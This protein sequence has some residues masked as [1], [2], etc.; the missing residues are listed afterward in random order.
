MISALLR[1]LSR[2][3][4]KMLKVVLVDDEPSVLEGLR[5]FVDWNDLGFEVA[6]EASDSESAYA[7]ILDKRPNLVVCDIRMPSVSGFELM[8]KVQATMEDA[9]RFIMISGYC[10]F[11][12]AQRAL[13]MG[14]LGYITKP[15]DAGDIKDELENAAALLSRSSVLDEE[16]RVGAF[17]DILDGNRDQESEAS[18]RAA[19]GSGPIF[20]VAI[21]EALGE[22]E[23]GALSILQEIGGEG[24]FAFGFGIGEFALVSSVALPDSG[25]YRRAESSMA[26]NRKFCLLA[27]NE[28]EA[29]SENA[30]EAISE[31]LAQIDKLQLWRLAHP[32]E[33]FVSME[34][35]AKTDPP[36]SKVFELPY[37]R[38][39]DALKDQDIKEAGAAVEELFDMLNQSGVD[40]SVYYICL[41]RLADVIARKARQA[42][43]D[44]GEALGEF[45]REASGA[46]RLSLGK[47]LQCRKKAL[48]MCQLAIERKNDDAERVAEEIVEYIKANRNK[49]LSLQNIS[50]AFSISPQAASR[51]VKKATGKKFNDVL[52]AQRIE[53]AKQLI[54]GNANMKIAAVCEASGYSDYVYFTSKFKELT[55]VSPSEYK[56]KFTS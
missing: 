50:D 23:E 49:S 24:S 56:R 31:C 14:A 33:T 7:L 32:A 29:K 47:A 2:E 17:N 5:I 41:C 13:H 54:A 10:D 37:S 46:R 43:A 34:K 40:A 4:V 22:N 55:G 30:F 39:A 1:S 52:N 44:I 35:A 6:G 26:K 20:R 38:I 53:C 15:L 45:M 27:S 21:L 11:Q 18:A 25:F 51:M 48:A 8:K 36:V 3:V 42:G 16:R 12:W 19:F 9:P 28:I